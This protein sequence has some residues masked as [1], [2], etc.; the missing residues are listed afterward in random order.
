MAKNYRLEILAAVAILAFCGVFLYT[1]STMTGA[2]FAG[3]DNVGSGLI[4][5]L[6]GKPVESFAPLIPQWQPP[7]GEIE[8]CLFAL[9]SAIGGIFVGG[10]FGYWLGQKK[11]LTEAKS[12]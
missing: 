5:E 7:S 8:A 6:S 10:V 9:Q 12:N 3:S 2:E 11:S 1:S 4:A